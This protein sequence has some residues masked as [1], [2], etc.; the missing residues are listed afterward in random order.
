M[1]TIKD[2][3]DYGYGK[4]AAHLAAAKWHPCS[5]RCQR[6]TVYAPLA[7]RRLPDPGSQLCDRSGNQ[8][9]AW[10]ETAW[11]P[12][13]STSS[14]RCWPWWF[15][16]NR[17][18]HPRTGLDVHGKTGPPNGDDKTREIAW[19]IGYTGEVCE[20]TGTRRLVCVTLDIPAGKV[21]FRGNIAKALLIK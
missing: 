16:G 6:R 3:A 15:P 5:R 12:Q 11:I 10:I 18:Q 19:I 4:A 8:P 17:P 13:R 14:T 20:S 7:S 2:L 1:V 9:T 21:D